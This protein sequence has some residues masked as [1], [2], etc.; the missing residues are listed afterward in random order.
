VATP[1]T[2]AFQLTGSHGG[3]LHG[4]VRTAGGPRP[5]VVICHGFDGSTAQ[6]LARAGFAAVTFDREKAA[7]S[8]QLRDLDVVLRALAAGRLGG[9]GRPEAIGLLGHGLSGSIAIQ[10]AASD[11]TPFALVTWAA[12]AR[13]ERLDV[14][15]AAALVR[16]PWL[17]VHGEADESVPAADARELSARAPAARLLMIADAGHTFGRAFAQVLDA[18]V[19]WFIRYLP[20]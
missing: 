4:E 19:E 18:T 10:R 1:S 8:G 13:L 12:R 2:I 17:I 7:A 5:A 9:G 16:A 15:A 11:P 6:R 14:T 20:R 3:P